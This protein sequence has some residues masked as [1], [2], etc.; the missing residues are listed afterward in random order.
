MIT[1]TV[2]V[3][4]TAFHQ[5]GCLPSRRVSSVSSL[6]CMASLPQSRPCF[7]ASAMAIGSL[8]PAY[9]RIP[10][11]QHHIPVPGNG[12]IEA[13]P[14]PAS[15]MIGTVAGSRMILHVVGVPDTESRPNRRKARGMTAAAPH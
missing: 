8:A 14:T 5:M 7:I 6:P 2:S 4:L 3:F 10:E 11:E 1:D 12:N 13:V 9:R 15:T